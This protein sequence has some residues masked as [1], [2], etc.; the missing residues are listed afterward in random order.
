MRTAILIAPD[1]G[2]LSRLSRLSAEFGLAW[3]AAQDADTAD[4]VVI[5]LAVPQAVEEVGRARKRWPCAVIAGYLDVPDPELW[6]AGQRAGADLVANRGALAVRLRP[7]LGAA[8]TG[9]RTFPLLQQADLGGRLGLVGRVGDTPVGPVAVYQ[10]DGEVCAVSDRC[11][12]AGASLS[13][14]ELEHRIVT[15]PR[16]GSQFDVCTGERVRGPADT[17]IARFAVV[18]ERGQVSLLLGTGSDLQEG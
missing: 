12:H 5:D 16:H 13:G 11:P 15:C 2:V 8:G 14:G 7:L 6:T 18:V 17:D 3:V 4:L 1:R 10:I 9:A